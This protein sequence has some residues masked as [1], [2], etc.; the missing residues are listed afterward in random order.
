M[1]LAE[2]EVDNQE[3]VEVRTYQGQEMGRQKNGEALGEFCGVWRLQREQRLP[4]SRSGRSGRAAV[5]KYAMP[6]CKLRGK[7]V[8][9]SKPK[10]PERQ[11]LKD[12]D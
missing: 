2:K 8:E 7:T 11:R 5:F 10:E 9:S 12:K 3:G 6:L 1:A 4:V